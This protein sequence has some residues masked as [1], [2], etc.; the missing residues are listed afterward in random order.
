M[1]LSSTASLHVLC[2]VIGQAW[3]PV[4]FSLSKTVVIQNLMIGN[5]KYTYTSYIEVLEFFITARG[6]W[7]YKI[8]F[9]K[10]EKPPF[11]Q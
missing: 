9:F 6:V 4:F 10:V 8:L 2:R 11:L 7:K 3:S 5:F 1:L